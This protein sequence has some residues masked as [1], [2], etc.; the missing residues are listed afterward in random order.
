MSALR[1]SNLP[2]LAVC[3]CF[4]G[5]AEGGADARRGILLDR[6]FRAELLGSEDR[7]ALR[8][9]LTGDEN[10]AVAWA[11]GEVRRLAGSSPLLVREDDC[12]I[13]MLGLQGTADAIAPDAMLLFDLKSGLRYPC[14]EQMA[15]YALGM[16]EACFTGSWT[17]H[18]LHCDRR[19]TE[20]LGFTYEEAHR[21]VTG[22]IDAV[23][24]P[25]R[26]P[27]P[28]LYCMWCAHEE[29]CTARLQTASEAMA[30]MDPGFDFAAVAADPAR[31]G[32]FLSA[33]TVLGEFRE[34]AAEAATM[35]LRSGGEVPGW[36]IE[37]V[38]G[39]ETVG[40]GTVGHHIGALGFG[41]VLA[42]CGD[43]PAASFRRLWEDRMPSGRPFPEDAVRRAEPTFRLRRTTT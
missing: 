23:R 32:R 43:M 11:A 4:E 16:M 31:L 36:E 28:C 21:M 30:S 27:V 10:A 17:C 24:N 29:T 34:K 2:K 12:R 8:E 15:A 13:T 20:T 19:E 1:P 37:E 6:A 35:I 42:A 25:G 41:P 5:R 26:Q 18:V 39:A 7:L 33:C 3:P 22:V 14:T 9:Q 38:P 40:A